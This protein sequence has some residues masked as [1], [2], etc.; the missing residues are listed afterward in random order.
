[1]QYANVY[2]LK[3]NGKKNSV[4]G[5]IKSVTS[6]RNLTEFS[7]N[8]ITLSCQEN[9]NHLGVV[10]DILRRDQVAVDARKRNFFDPVNS[11]VA[12]MG[13]SCLS[14]ST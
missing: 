7:L 4:I 9:I 6:S 1:M 8:G 5:F 12:R 10:L 14:D 13:G 2:H 11:A 3:I